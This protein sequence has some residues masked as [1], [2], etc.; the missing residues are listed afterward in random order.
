M[1]SKALQTGEIDLDANIAYLGAHPPV[2]PG[3]QNRITLV[4]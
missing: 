4:L 3:P 1:S 2:A